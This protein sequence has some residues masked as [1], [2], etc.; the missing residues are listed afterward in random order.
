MPNG[1]FCK[2]TRLHLARLPLIMEDQKSP[3][4][5]LGTI[6]LIKKSLLFGVYFE[7]VIPKT[8]FMETEALSKKDAE[9]A[10]RRQHG[11][12]PGFKFLDVYEINHQPTYRAQATQQ[13]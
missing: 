3:L 7:Y 11:N 4:P 8:V 12:L 5:G 1:W 6:P 13:K 9:L 2:E 10:V